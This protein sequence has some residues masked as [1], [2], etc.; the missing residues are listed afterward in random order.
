VP[1]STS[2]QLKKPF[3]PIS[4]FIDEQQ[5]MKENVFVECDIEYHQII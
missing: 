3:S 5:L 1:L 4:Q 2:Q